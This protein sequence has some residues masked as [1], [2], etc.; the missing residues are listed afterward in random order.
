MRGEQFVSA[1]VPQFARL[2]AVSMRRVGKR[3]QVCPRRRRGSGGQMKPA[4]PTVWRTEVWLGIAF[5]KISIHLFRHFPGVT[6]NHR[7]NARVNA[8]WSA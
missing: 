2:I 6:S 8:A 5:S 7:T 4:D 1:M 3:F